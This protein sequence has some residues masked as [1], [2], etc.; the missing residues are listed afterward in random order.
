MRWSQW[1]VNEGKDRY[2]RDHIYIIGIT[3]CTSNDTIVNRE[4]ANRKSSSS[5]WVSH[6]NVNVN[7]YK[8]ITSY[9]WCSQAEC[10]IVVFDV[11]MFSRREWVNILRALLCRTGKTGGVDSRLPT[12][13][14]K[15]GTG[16]MG[17]LQDTKTQPGPLSLAPEWWLSVKQQPSVPVCIPAQQSS[18]DHGPGVPFKVKIPGP[19]HFHSMRLVTTIYL[20]NVSWPGYIVQD[21]LSVVHAHIKCYYLS[22]CVKGKVVVLN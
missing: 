11:G 1:V 20:T 16:T 6:L 19:V 10:C 13:L 4:A 17:Q 12:P 2:I 21:S 14:L 22:P 8:L 9:K 18:R 3:K 5:P 15:H 7:T